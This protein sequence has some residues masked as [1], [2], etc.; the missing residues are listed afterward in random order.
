MCISVSCK[1]GSVKGHIA[2]DTTENGYW[3]S[4]Q[5]GGLQEGR[6]IHN[7]I[8]NLR[9]IMEKATEFSQPLFLCFIDFH[10]TFVGQKWTVIMYVEHRL[11]TSSGWTTKENV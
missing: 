2:K 10:K 4:A 1:Q 5:T 8:T 6:S 3:N 7:Q 9:I 11:S